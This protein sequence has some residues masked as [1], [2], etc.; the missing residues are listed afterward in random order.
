MAGRVI[1]SKDPLKDFY[2]SFE[3]KSKS[4]NSLSTRI[5]SE[6]DVLNLFHWLSKAKEKGYM[7]FRGTTESNYKH[8]SHSQRQFSPLM[9]TE[10]SFELFYELII[11]S[12]EYA[13]E[14]NHGTIKNYLLKRGIEGNLFAYLSLMQHY[15]IPTPLIDFTR[16]PY[17]ALFFA[18]KKTLEHKNQG[19]IK[20]YCSLYFINSNY[21]YLNGFGRHFENTIEVNLRNGYSKERAFF[22][23]LRFTPH[24]IIDENDQLFQINNNINIVN[25]EGLFILNGEPHQP[26]EDQHS[27]QMEMRNES[28]KK[29]STDEANFISTKM[30]GCWE[31]HKSINAYIINK[32]FDE[33]GITYSFLFPDMQRLRSDFEREF[34]FPSN[35]D[36]SREGNYWKK[37]ERAIKYNL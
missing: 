31:I 37:R 35:F 6:Q 16:N 7:I 30:F 23:G 25:Q 2:I 22:Y 36:V 3:E 28:L 19:D 15:G 32:L 17:V 21:K 20:D 5:E 8:Y 24:L 18:T 10:E 34:E 11:D 33:M 27:L 9:H 13:K 12:V 14:W 1:Q 29:N 26:L 4:I